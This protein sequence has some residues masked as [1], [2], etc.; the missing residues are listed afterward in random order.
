MLR[1]LLAF[2]R[3]Q[4]LRN[5]VFWIVALVFGAMAFAIMTTDAV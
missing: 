1:H 3:R 5:G 2:E 4:V